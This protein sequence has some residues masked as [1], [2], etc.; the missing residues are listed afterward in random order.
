MVKVDGRT[1]SHGA[2]CART[3]TIF[4]LG[5]EMTRPLVR[6]DERPKF[7]GI[8]LDESKSCAASLECF[9]SNKKL[10]EKKSWIANHDLYMTSFGRVMVKSEDIYMDAITGTFYNEDG[11]CRSSSTLELGEVWKDQECAA[12]QLMLLNPDRGGVE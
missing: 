4:I 5:E 11:Q 1:R 8:V 10:T 9:T 3:E 7:A 12:S 6:V 2:L